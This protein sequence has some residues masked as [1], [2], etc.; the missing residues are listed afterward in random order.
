[1]NAHRPFS[2]EDDFMPALLCTRVGPGMRDN[3]RTVEV[4]D[5]FGQRDF[6]R[7]PQGHRLV[8]QPTS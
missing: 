5:I 6:L 1:M 2:G 8:K 4:K 3:E 7:V